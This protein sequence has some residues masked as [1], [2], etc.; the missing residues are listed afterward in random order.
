MVSPRLLAPSRNPGAMYFP[1][2]LIGW[3]FAGSEG[4]VPA[5][6]QVKVT[7]FHKI[8]VMNPAF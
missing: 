1:V 3:V 6:E 5:G 8:T 4:G 7:T 2:V